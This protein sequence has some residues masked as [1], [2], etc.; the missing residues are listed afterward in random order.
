MRIPKKALVSFIGPQLH[1]YRQAHSLSQEKM[2]RQLHIS[3]R[4]YSD[5]ENQHH[6]ISTTTLVQFMLLMTTSELSSFLHDLH[7]FAL[8][9]P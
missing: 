5:L 3:V 9:L 2:A 4:S 8:P 1:T 6:C 7:T